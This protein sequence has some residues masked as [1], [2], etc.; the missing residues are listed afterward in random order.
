MKIHEKNLDAELERLAKETV[1]AAYKL[2]STLGPGLLESVYETFFCHE[3]KRRGL[4][5]EKQVLLP[6][7]YEGLTFDG[8]LKMDILIEGRLIVELKAVELLLPIHKV[9]LTTYLKLSGRQF[10]LLI[11]F[12][13]PMIKDGIR[14]V[15][16]SGN[17]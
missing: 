12:N 13:V 2:H 4:K 5:V 7:T 17:K 3:L 9:Q 10:G 1:D 6:L 15:I 14:R 11:N 16:L 8:G